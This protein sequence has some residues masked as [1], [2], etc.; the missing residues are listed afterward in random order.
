MLDRNG[1]FVR[2]EI[3][4]GSWNINGIWQRINSFRYNKLQNPD[5]LNLTTSKQ[6]F[7]LIE[8]HHKANEVANLHITGYKCYSL[9]RP[10]DKNVKKYKPSGGLA[11]YVH[12]T[13]K[14]GI[15]KVPMGGTEVII[16]KL[17]KEFFGT[18]TDLYLCFAYCVPSNSSVLANNSCMPH[19]VYEDLQD[20]LSQCSNDGQLILLGDMNARTKNMADFITNENNLHVPVPPPGG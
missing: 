20:K 19:D 9:C 3:K 18:M 4:I 17:K 7:G 15:S 11:V 6:I 13:L 12:E 1:N 5:V 2:S 10:K 14:A 16:L 8:S